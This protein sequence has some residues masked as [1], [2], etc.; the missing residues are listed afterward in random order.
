MEEWAGVMRGGGFLGVDPRRY[1]SDLGS[2]FGFGRSLAAIPTRWPS[3]EP[4]S[5]E[6][7]EAFLKERHSD[8]P[9]LQLM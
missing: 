2:F 6:Q 3:P 1:P 7:V 9:K 5:L 8:S 4:L